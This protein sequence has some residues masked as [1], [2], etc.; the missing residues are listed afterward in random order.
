MGVIL[1]AGFCVLI[2]SIFGPTELGLSRAA[3]EQ[4]EWF[5]IL[6][7]VF[8][9]YGVEH[10]VTNIVTLIL[11]G[12]IANEIELSNATFLAIFF[13]AGILSALLMLPF[14]SSI[15]VGASTG[16]Y[17]IFGVIAVKLRDYGA[18]VPKVIGLFTLAIVGSSLIE[19]PLGSNQMAIRLSA[20]LTALFLGVILFV[21]AQS[22]RSRFK[23][24]R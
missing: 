18:S 22:W 15:L 4:G 10:L 14:T 6:S 17:G 24:T 11:A 20:H 12:A 23:R 5:R 3:L 1:I 9:H 19:V 8:S 7:F 13:G 16:V 21:A 2:N